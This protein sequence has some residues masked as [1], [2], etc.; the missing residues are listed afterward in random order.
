M[1]KTS[2][3]VILF[4]YLV[5]MKAVAVLVLNTATHSLALLPQCWN[6]MCVTPY[7]FLLLLLFYF[8]LSFT[9]ILNMEIL[10][11]SFSV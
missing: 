9:Q 5:C 4:L 7:L 1:K 3:F 10:R 8:I 6:Y 11:Q 2:I